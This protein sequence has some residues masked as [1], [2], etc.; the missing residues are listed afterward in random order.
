[1]AMQYVNYIRSSPYL[2]W[3]PK[4]EKPI[5]TDDDEQFLNRITTQEGGATATEL[6]DDQRVRD[7]QTALMDG[8]QNIPLPETPSEEPKAELGDA[9]KDGES[10][11]DA[12]PRTYWTFMRRDSRDSKRK[13]WSSA[14]ERKQNT[15][16][17]IGSG[18][19]SGQSH[20]C[21][22]ADKE[23]RCSTK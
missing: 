12:K 4:S 21:C 8:A 18:S 15:N 22:R 3:T 13:V 2:N 20:G 19:Y 7:A 1:M 9:P 5:L 16:C 14:R 11:T 23:C 6:A 17:C 10:K